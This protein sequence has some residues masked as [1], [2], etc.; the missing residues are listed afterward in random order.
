[1]EQGGHRENGH[2]SAR[3]SPR[4]AVPQKEDKA[5]AQCVGYEYVA[6]PQQI[7][8]GE[9]KA[10]QPEHAPVVQRGGSTAAGFDP[11]R[12][13]AY[14]GAEQHGEYGDEFGVGQQMAEVPDREVDAGQVSPHRRIQVGRFWHRECLD[15]HDQDAQNGETAQ[16][17]QAGDAVA[18]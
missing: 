2:P 7:S 1:M 8:V 14:T 13:Q 5:S 3:Q 6:N 11:V 9:P 18:C 17:V 16:D 12:E 10:E 15:I 4:L